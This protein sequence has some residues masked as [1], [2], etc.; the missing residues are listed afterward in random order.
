M[1]AVSSLPELKEIF[2]SRYWTALYLHRQTASYPLQAGNPETPVW[3]ATFGTPDR[4]WGAARHQ[5]TT[6]LPFPKIVNLE[7]MKDLQGI[8]EYLSHRDKDSS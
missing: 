8:P 6:L 3:R 2:T 1:D 4:I 5:K 7:R